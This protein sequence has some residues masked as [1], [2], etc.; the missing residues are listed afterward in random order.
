MAINMYLPTLFILVALA[1]GFSKPSLNHFALA[2]R[3]TT[4]VQ[5][6]IIHEFPLGT[7]VENLVVRSSDPP[8][9]LVTVTSSPDLYL[10]STTSAYPPIHVA[11]L[12]GYVSLL[13]ITQL[14]DDLFYFIA[15]DFS[16]FT[17][18]ATPG[19]FSIFELDLRG[20]IPTPPWPSPPS[21]LDSGIRKVADIPEAAFLNGLTTLNPVGGIILAADSGPGVVWGVNVNSGSYS[22]AVNDST[23]AVAL[24][25]GAHIGINGAHFLNGYLYYTNTAQQSFSRIPV[26]A[27]TGRASGPA[28]VLIHQPPSGLDDFILDF[29]GNAWLCEDLLAQILLVPAITTLSNVATNAVV[30]ELVSSLTLS[31]GSGLYG[32][33][34]AAFG[35]SPQDLRAGSLYFAT[36]GGILQ[37]E[38]RN[39]TQGGTLSR[40]DLAAYF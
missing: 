32:A 19:S 14:A 28:E 21:P 26:N 4:Q 25:T 27:S 9:I 20:G 35:V 6:E 36:T 8:S 29:A 15:G 1:F 7:W 38:G 18:E 5:A 12:P 22:V 17:L 31:N 10:V 23:M 39:W 33:T 37:Y 34:A 24:T 2:S 13:G 11:H 40:L 3:D 16:V 30:P